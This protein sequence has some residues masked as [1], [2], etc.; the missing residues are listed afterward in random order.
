MNDYRNNL[1]E[2][3]KSSPQHEFKQLRTDTSLTGTTPTNRVITSFQ[4]IDSRNSAR[5]LYAANKNRNGMKSEAAK[6]ILQPKILDA[7]ALCSSLFSTCEN[8]K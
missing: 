2:V 5:D 7:Q 8:R 1:R 6:S 3:M 4:T